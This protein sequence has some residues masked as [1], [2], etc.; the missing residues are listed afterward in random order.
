MDRDP[1]MDP[2]ASP[3]RPGV[4]RM[5][6]LPVAILGGAVAVFLGIMAYVAAG[7]AALR[8][9][10]EDKDA[11][12]SALALAKSVAGDHEAGTVPA[13]EAAA[14]VTGSAAN[15]SQPRDAAPLPALTP[16][17]TDFP[18]PPQPP[19][20]LGGGSD[21]ALLPP[22]SA[23]GSAQSMG[24]E[25]GATTSYAS[26]SA[27]SDDARD[28]HRMRWEMFKQAVRAKTA[29]MADANA[30]ASSPQPIIASPKCERSSPRRKRKALAVTTSRR[31]GNSEKPGS[32][33][34]MVSP[35]Q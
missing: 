23:Q 21:S 20:L 8:D 17:R 11:V 18:A 4:R 35:M 15:S 13:A 25:P 30:A 31:F 19:R 28:L 22:A 26:A 1:V 7:R 12:R 9:G 24:S 32:F 34:T 6:N 27:V 29:T 10:P 14:A 5:N 3:S 16:G 33:R 2:A